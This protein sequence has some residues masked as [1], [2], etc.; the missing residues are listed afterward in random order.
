MT[1]S[2]SKGSDGTG[3]DAAGA[4][5]HVQDLSFAIGTICTRRN[6]GRPWEALSSHE[7]AIRL[8]AS[9]RWMSSP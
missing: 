3:G 2:A 1:S 7:I 5:P 8:A 6:R 9:L 4:A